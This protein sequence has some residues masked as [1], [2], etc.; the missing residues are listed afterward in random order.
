MGT[1]PQGPP[2]IELRTPVLLL[3]LAA[4]AAP[5]GLRNPQSVDLSIVRHDLA[6]IV[7]NIMGFLP[8]GIVLARIGPIKAVVVAALLSLFVEAAQIV[9]LFRWPALADLV[10]NTV[11]A[12]LG[13]FVARRFAIT[14]T[15]TATRRLAIGSGLLAMMLIAVVQILRLSSGTF[16]DK[17]TGTRGNGALEAH[18]T[19]NESSGA[20]VQDVSGNGRTGRYRGSPERLAGPPV[21]AVRLGGDDDYIDFGRPAGLLLTGSLT[22]SAWVK[23]SSFPR[24]DAAIVSSHNGLGFQLDTTID[25][26]SRTIGFKLGSTCGTLMARY[27]ATPLQ[28]ETWYFLTGVYD[29]DAESIDVYLNGILDNGQLV[30]PVTGSQRASKVNV[31]IG[32]RND[33]GYGFTGEIGDVRIYSRALSADEIKASMRGSI[34]ASSS[35]KSGSRPQATD[36]QSACWGSSDPE[37]AHLPGAAAL[38]GVLTAVAC[39]GFLPDIGL[40][41]LLICSATA[42]IL[43]AP[44]AL[45]QLAAFVAI[46]LSAAGGGAVAAAVRPGLQPSHTNSIQV[47]N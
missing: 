7:L 43:L 27:G 5:I 3:V 34:P 39:V 15:L 30:G 13:V 42:G 22:V 47:S 4:T 9:M 32:R 19:F 37:D 10:T 16:D 36:R 45:S 25:T 23:S 38:L 1:S 44:A 41:P 17:D 21:D 11:G 8:V 31:L 29:A 33:N 26:G 28:L 14:P 35:T 40:L 24:D 20:I 18:W 12:G 2:L 6:D 46:L